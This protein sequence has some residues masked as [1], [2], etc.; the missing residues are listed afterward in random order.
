MTLVRTRL[1]LTWSLEI[2]F[3]ECDLENLREMEQN[4]Y[5]FPMYFKC[6]CK[7][8]TI[9]F[10][11]F[12]LFLLHFPQIFQPSSRILISSDQVSSDLIQTSL[13]LLVLAVSIT[14]QKEM[15]DLI[16]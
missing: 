3:R 9:R 2:H 1:E 14:F 7:I 16:T 10:S 12:E 4:F 8:P 13:I 15:K 11:N 5:D 6:I